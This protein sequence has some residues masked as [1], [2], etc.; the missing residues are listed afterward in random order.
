MT[1]GSPS[2]HGGASVDENE[3]FTRDYKSLEVFRQT[4]AK[5]VLIVCREE[6]TA[7]GWRTW[8]LLETKPLRDWFNH[9]QRLFRES[10]W[11]GS[12]VQISSQTTGTDAG[13]LRAFDREQARRNGRA[14]RQL[15]RISTTNNGPGNHGS[16]LGTQCDQTNCDLTSYRPTADAEMRAEHANWGS[17]G[18]IGGLI[19]S[20]RKCNH[21]C[22]WTIS[23]GYDHDYTIFV[24]R[25]TFSDICDK[26]EAAP[27]CS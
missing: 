25:G 27:Q 3:C 2:A 23:S 6:G 14:L 5:D 1:S 22:S 21:G 7:L 17:S 11:R 16:G 19:G 12:S 9:S 18:G 26:I 4:A 24:M 15:N 8:K 10:G 13:N 20:D